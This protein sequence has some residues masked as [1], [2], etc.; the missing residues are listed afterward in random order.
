MPWKRFKIRCPELK[1][2][3]FKAMSKAWY[4]KS[5][6]IA[7]QIDL[8][9]ISRIEDSQLKEILTYRFEKNMMVRE[10]SEKLHYALRH[11]YRLINKAIAATGK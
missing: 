4:G 7:G 8:E 11:T 3:I 10:I 9:S 5:K 2:C 1:A 6:E